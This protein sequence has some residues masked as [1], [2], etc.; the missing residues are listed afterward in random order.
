MLDFGE[1]R[2]QE[3]FLESLQKNKYSDLVLLCILILA[4]LI[5]IIASATLT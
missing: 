5:L 3:T 1:R 2:V 4:F